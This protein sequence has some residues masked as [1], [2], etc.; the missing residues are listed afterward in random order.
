M[1]VCFLKETLCALGGF[2][3]PYLIGGKY[4]PSDGTDLIRVE[5]LQQG[6]AG[7]DLDIITMRTQAQHIDWFFICQ[8]KSQHRIG[9]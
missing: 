4:Y 9:F 2:L 1:V 6:S 3:F 5:K 7:A 8:Q